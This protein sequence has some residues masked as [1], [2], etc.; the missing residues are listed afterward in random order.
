M[1]TKKEKLPNSRLKLI[2]TANAAQFRHAFGHELEEVAK[3]VKVPGFRPGKAPAAKVIQ[4]AGRQRIEASALDHAISEV[5]FMDLREEKIT[6]VGNPSIEITDYVAPADDAS[7]D[8][9]VITFTAEVD[10][11]PEIEIKGYEKIKVKDVEQ[12]KITE[13]EVERVIEYLRK[14]HAQAEAAPEGTELQKG[15][16]VDLGYEGSVDGV[17]RTDMANKNHPI[18]LGEGQLIPGFEEN[19]EGLKVGDVKTFKITF[20]KDY[21]TQELANKEAEFTVTINEIKTITLPEKDEKFAENYGHK[22]FAELEK[23]IRENLHEEK[24]EQTKQQLEEN[25]VDE[26]IKLAKFELPQ[27]L[28]EQELQRLFAESRQR[29]EG[30]QFQWDAYLEQTGKTMEQLKE[31]MRPQAEKNVRIGLAL[32]RVIE[33]EKIPSGETA[34]RQAVDRL[35]EI[36]TKK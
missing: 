19:L 18:V 11:L 29:L 15:M 17:K 20:P 23:A 26:L 16:W 14:Q 35:V 32:G 2:H 5:Y 33:E 4:A 7:D 28:V 31:E 22:N 13:D 1:I 24:Q 27:A 8:E 6:P 9:K 30:M 21:G 10:V 3:T 12:P 34:A 36:A 25:V